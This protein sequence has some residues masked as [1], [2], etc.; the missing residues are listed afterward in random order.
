MTA[1]RSAIEKASS[2]SCVTS[3][4]VTPMLRRISAR[5]S[6]IGPRRSRWMFSRARRAAR[7][8]ARVRGP[9]PVRRAAAGRRTAHADSDRRGR[10]ARPCRARRPPVLF[11]SAAGRQSPR[12]RPPSGAG[13][14]RNPGRPCPRGASRVAP[15][16]PSPATLTSSRRTS[17]ASGCSKPAIRRRRVVLPHPLRAEQ[18]HQLTA[19]DA[20]LGFVDGLHRAEALRDAVYADHPAGHVRQTLHCEY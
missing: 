6:R 17:P 14:A 9:A 2:R 15:M 8:W 10:R 13:R 3:T 12:S 18:G 16:L 5:S 20:E 7:A 4:T 1:I 19:L 11:A